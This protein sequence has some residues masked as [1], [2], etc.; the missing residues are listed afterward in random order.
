MRTMEDA[1]REGIP[2]GIMSWTAV[3]LEHARVE[4]RRARR[5]RW[6]RVRL[7]FGQALLALLPGG[8]RA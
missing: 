2:D 7:W 4:R 5:R 6:R 1:M 3:R 8:G